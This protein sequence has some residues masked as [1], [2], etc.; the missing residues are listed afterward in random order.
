MVSKEVVEK[1]SQLMTAAFGLVAALAWNEVIQ[2]LF[3]PGGPLAYTAAFGPWVYAIFVTIIA[4]VATV[5]IGRVAR[6]AARDED[7]KGKKK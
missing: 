3:K 1:A 4:A 6:R 7:Q 5:W 2:S